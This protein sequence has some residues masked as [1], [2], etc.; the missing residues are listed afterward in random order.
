[1][2]VTDRPEETLHLVPVVDRQVCVASHTVIVV[3]ERRQWQPACY[4]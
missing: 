3:D 1:M 4:D 2:E